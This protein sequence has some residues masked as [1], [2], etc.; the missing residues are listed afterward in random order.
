MPAWFVPKSEM[1]EQTDIATRREQQFDDIYLPA[2]A[3]PPKFDRI[4]RFVSRLLN[5]HRFVRMPVRTEE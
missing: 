4:E 3:L 2:V 5:R 1:K